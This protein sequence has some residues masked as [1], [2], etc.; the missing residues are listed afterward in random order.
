MFG[1]ICYTFLIFSSIFLILQAADTSLET[2]QKDL[3]KK[4]WVKDVVYL[5]EFPRAL[6]VPI[7]SPFCIKLETFLRAHNIKYEVFG[8]WTVRSKE[9]R[10]PFIELNGE[11]IADSQIILWHLYKHFNIDEGLTVEQQGVSRAIDRM[12]EGSAYY[13]IT[14]IRSYLH[15]EEC[16]DYKIS[17]MKLNWAE[18]KAAVWKLKH[19]TESKLRNEGTMLHSEEDIFEILRRDIDAL[20]E[21]LGTKKFMLGDKPSLAD[22]T[23][24]GH[25]GLIYYLPF[26]EPSKHFLEQERYHNVRD[27]IARMREAYWKNDWERKGITTV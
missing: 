12:V 11:Q 26:D 25:L 6:A 3:R 4:D 17:G 7:L 24:F 9:G 18:K 16:V 20:S 21:I 22:L 23:V 5:Y 27:L 13:P 10:V 19:D 15:A 2:A 14:Y 1:K 8:S